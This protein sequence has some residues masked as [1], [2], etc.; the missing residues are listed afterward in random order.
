VSRAKPNPRAGW[1]AEWWS[2]AAQG[3]VGIGPWFER[4]IEAKDFESTL[5]PL[6]RTTRVRLARPGQ[7]K[8]GDRG[9]FPGGETRVTAIEGG[10]QLQG[11]KSG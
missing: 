6:A 11:S 5:A 2:P 3:W 7:L 4:E 10:A 9:S 1:R 8:L